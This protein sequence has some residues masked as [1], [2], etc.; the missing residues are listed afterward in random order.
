MNDNLQ[1]WI[2]LRPEH[3]EPWSFIQ[4]SPCDELWSCVGHM[5]Y[6]YEVP[7]QYR[8]LF[9]PADGRMLSKN[10]YAAAYAV[11]G[12]SYGETDQEF[13]LPNTIEDRRAVIKD[14]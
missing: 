6:H 11:I 12:G 1:P 10:D 7:G 5:R 4:V 9:M 2:D 13:A 14:K 8:H 3:G